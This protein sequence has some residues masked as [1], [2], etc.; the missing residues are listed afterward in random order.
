MSRS[1]ESKFQVHLSST[2]AMFQYMT[3]PPFKTLPACWK[4]NIIRLEESSVDVGWN[5][6][7]AQVEL[8][9]RQNEPNEFPDK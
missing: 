3:L 8:M 1:S 2:K 5:V 7:N 6:W 4:R 9:E